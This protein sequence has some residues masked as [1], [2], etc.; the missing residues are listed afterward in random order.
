MCSNCLL[1]E[2]SSSAK[3]K[4]LFNCNFQTKSAHQVEVVTQLLW[5]ILDAMTKFLHTWVI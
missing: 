1:P 4:L 2:M 3:K 5:K